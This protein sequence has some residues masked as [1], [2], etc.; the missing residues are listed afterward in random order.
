VFTRE[1]DVHDDAT[2]SR[3]YTIMRAAELYG[4]EHMPFWSEREAAVMFRRDE[5]GEAWQCFAA[6]EGEGGDETMVGIGLVI[7]P[8][9][10]NVTF[11]FVG[12]DVPPEHRGRGVGT[13]LA[14]LVIAE[15]RKA[16]RT[17]LLSEVNLA[18]EHRENHPYRR[19]A[20][21]RGFVLANVEVRRVLDLPVSDAMIQAWIDESA[22]HYED[23]RI[24]TYVDDVPDE[25]LPSLVHV[26]NQLA[27]D[28]PTGD[29]EFEAEAMTPDAFKIRR[30]KLKEMGRTVYE[31]LA[32]APDGD[33]VA[34][35]TLAVSSDDPD[36]AFQW[37]TL[38]RRDHRGHRLGMAVKSTNLR[39]MQQAHPDTT[40]II[41]TNSEANAPMVGINEQLGFKPVELLAEFQVKFDEDE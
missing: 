1:I 24:E 31:T 8:L 21:H 22:P 7:L 15:A 35:S 27:V 3:Y 37:G 29:L 14:D 41:T 20:E 25:L 34:H 38:V 6:F 10:D 11:A 33:V 40:R 28:A 39:A 17:R 5:P 18:F 19:F 23:Y 26:I 4:R 32:I 16:G 30:A 36:N 9:L 13:A 2:F 12:V